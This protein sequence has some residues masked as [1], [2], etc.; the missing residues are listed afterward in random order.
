MLRPAGAA[1]TV[2]IAIT[3]GGCLSVRVVRRH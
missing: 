3:I 2:L 1:L